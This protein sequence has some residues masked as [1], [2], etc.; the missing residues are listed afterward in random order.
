MHGT[1]W[2]LEAVTKVAAYRWDPLKRPV[3][4]TI[5]APLTLQELKKKIQ[6]SGFENFGLISMWMQFDPDA[7][8]LNPSRRLNSPAWQALCSLFG[9][10]VD[11]DVFDFYI[12]G[13]HRATSA[14]KKR[15]LKGELPPEY[16]TAELAR[17]IKK[18][19]ATKPVWMPTHLKGKAFDIAFAALEMSE[20]GALN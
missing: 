5:G 17:A 2:L 16:T 15:K 1:K 19:M 8:S 12:N 4:Y 3:G 20:A 9:H 6:P 18:A 11:T 13:F 10:N 14:Q 7:A